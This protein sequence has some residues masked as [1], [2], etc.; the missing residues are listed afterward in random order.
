MRFS[1][2]IQPFQP[3]ENS[4]PFLWTTGLS[5]P[6]DPMNLQPVN[7]ASVAK[8]GVWRLRSLGR[9]SGNG[10]NWEVAGTG[11]YWG[12]WDHLQKCFFWAMQLGTES[13]LEELR[14]LNPVIAQIFED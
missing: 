4:H 7:F 9:R 14:Q 11:M 8:F 6:N 12:I 3:K 10:W 1:H 2:C 13:F 5:N